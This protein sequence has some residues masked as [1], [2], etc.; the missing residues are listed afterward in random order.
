MDGGSVSYRSTKDHDNARCQ[1]LKER[2]DSF[3]SDDKMWFRIL[4][5]GR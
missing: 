4:G 3:V 1:V 2:G 5:M